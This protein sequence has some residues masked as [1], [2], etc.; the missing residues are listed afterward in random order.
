MNYHFYLNQKKISASQASAMNEYA[1]RLTAY[2]KTQRYLQPKNHITEIL[3]SLV[4]SPHTLWIQITTSTDT[5]T[6]EELASYFNQMSV[7]GISTVCFFLGYE[8][9]PG[10]TMK[11]STLSLTSLNFSTD[12]LGV[13]LYEQIYRSYRILNN[14]PYHK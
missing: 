4:P 3:S 10:E 5:P 13:L 14:Q 7:N 1:K 6:S 12:M 8:G 9:I 11:V 2:C